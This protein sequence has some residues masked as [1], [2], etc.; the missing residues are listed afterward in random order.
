MLREAVRKSLM[1][2]CNALITAG[3]IRLLESEARKEQNIAEKR[4]ILS[5]GVD[6]NNLRQVVI[7]D[8]DKRSVI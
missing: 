1:M 4:G 5:T 6:T 2:E 8:N 7:F 3:K